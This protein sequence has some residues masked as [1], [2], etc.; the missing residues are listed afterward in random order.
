MA[1]ATQKMEVSESKRRISAAH[2]LVDGIRPRKMT[3]Y[4]FLP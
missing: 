4:L 2:G 3:G 1:T